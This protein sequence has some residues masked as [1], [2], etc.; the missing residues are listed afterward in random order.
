MVVLTEFD[1]LEK[2]IDAFIRRFKQL[3]LEN[4]QLHRQLNEALKSQSHFEK[5]H[6]Q[7]HTELKRLATDLQERLL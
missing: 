1:A 3:Q 7:V 4:Y 5:K 2:S 6:Q